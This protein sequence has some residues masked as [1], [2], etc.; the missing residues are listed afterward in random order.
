MWV[1]LSSGASM[2]PAHARA[3]DGE[4]RVVQAR[5]LVDN[6]RAGL[7]CSALPRRALGPR[8]LRNL[9]FCGLARPLEGSRRV[10][11]PAAVVASASSPNNILIFRRTRMSVRPSGAEKDRGHPRC[12]TSRSQAQERPS[13]WNGASSARKSGRR[14]PRPVGPERGRRPCWSVPK[15]RRQKTDSR[16]PKRIVENCQAGIKVSKRT[17]QRYM[18]A[19]R[20]QRDALPPLSVARLVHGIHRAAC[21][22]AKD[23]VASRSRPVERQRCSLISRAELRPLRHS[24]SIH[25]RDGA[26]LRERRRDVA[27]QIARLA[28]CRGLQGTGRKPFRWVGWPG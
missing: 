12:R 27:L 26:P 25:E 1:P 28:R 23:L 10:A 6:S 2:A 16:A 13:Q 17:I 3:Y 21:D 22:T 7:T 18:R 24:H 8:G 9:C 20:L 14:P 15:S 4:S 11:T 5:A 19:A